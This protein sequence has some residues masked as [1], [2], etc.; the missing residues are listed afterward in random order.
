MAPLVKVEG[1]EWWEGQQRYSEQCHLTLWPSSFHLSWVHLRL[2]SSDVDTELKVGVNM[3][4]VPRGGSQGSRQVGAQ[5]VGGWARQ[6]EQSSRGSLI[7]QGPW[8]PRVTSQQSLIRNKGAS[9]CIHLGLGSQ[10]GKIHPRGTSDGVWR[11]IWLPPWEK[12]GTGTWCAEV[13]DAAEHPSMHQ[14]DPSTPTTHHCV[15]PSVHLAAVEKLWSLV[16]GYRQDGH[17]GPLEDFLVVW[18]QQIL[19]LWRENLPRVCVRAWGAWV[20]HWQAALQNPGNYV[21]VFSSLTTFSV[22]AVIWLNVSGLQTLSF[23]IY[24]IP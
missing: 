23:L 15:A 5:R 12:C 13:G 4:S 3:G 22:S 19:A 6:W 16:Q 17:L 7:P 21:S 24:V 11:H 14:T 8:N 10:L 18:G 9:T 20:A 1:R 2:S